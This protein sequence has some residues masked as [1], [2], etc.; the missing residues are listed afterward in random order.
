[1]TPTVTSGDVRSD[2]VASS[3][4]V[5]AAG[6]AAIGPDMQQLR[7]SYPPRSCPPRWSATQLSTEDVL[8]RLRCAPL[9]TEASENRDTLQRNAGGL[10]RVLGWLSDHPGDTWQAR[11]L[12]SGADS[13]GN[14][15]WVCPV[16]SR[17]FW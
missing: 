11:W 15:K 9:P 13:M 12:A 17:R 14:A 7:R 2:R 8:A 16:F 3:A 10:R 5:A 6:A 4:G 1:M